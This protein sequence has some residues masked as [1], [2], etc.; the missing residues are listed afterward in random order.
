MFR[1]SVKSAG[2][3]LPPVS[4]SLSLPCVTVCH[5]IST[6]LYQRS[7]GMFCLHIRSTEALGSSKMFISISLNEVIAHVTRIWANLLLQAILKF[8]VML[9]LST[10]NF[11]ANWRICMKNGI[12]SVIMETISPC[13][14]S[15][16][17]MDWHILN[18]SIARRWEI[19]QCLLYCI[20]YDVTQRSK[21]LWCVIQNIAW[22]WGI[23]VKHAV[24]DTFFVS[25]VE[26]SLCIPHRFS[27]T[28]VFV[29][30]N[31]WVVPR[32]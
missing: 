23:D 8:P 1:G 21:F 28:T 30:N 25:L 20:I 3:P 12:R 4:A 6:G 10:Y 5:H 27:D 11:W 24:V 15:C 17:S 16:R 29:I 26:C 18:T 7:C 13:A 32:P 19:T 14:R 2:Y 31:G 9:C 22:L